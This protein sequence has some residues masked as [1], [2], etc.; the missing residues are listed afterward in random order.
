MFLVKVTYTAPLGEV[1]AWRP[2][3]GDWLRELLGRRLLLLAGRRVPLT[4]GVYL[5]PDMPADA[6]EGLLATDPYVVNGVAAHEVVAFTPL[7]A[8]EGLEGLLEP[9][10]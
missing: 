8:A 7:M 4:G 1:D 3:H 5:A 9:T 6:L 10:G 2:A